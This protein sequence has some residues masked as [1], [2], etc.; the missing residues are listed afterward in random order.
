[1][2]QGAGIADVLQTMV[3]MVFDHGHERPARLTC[4]ECS[5]FRV[6]GSSQC[7]RALPSL[8]TRAEPLWVTPHPS[9]R[10]VAASSRTPR[11]ALEKKYTLLLIQFSWISLRMQA[12]KITSLFQA[13][14]ASLR[15]QARGAEM[16]EVWSGPPLFARSREDNAEAQAHW[17][18]ISGDQT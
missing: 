14:I 1:M 5:R 16:F 7:S 2:Q 8:T 9:L 6:W 4:R 18:S 3:T 12:V 17:A 15:G 13:R 11:S 10:G